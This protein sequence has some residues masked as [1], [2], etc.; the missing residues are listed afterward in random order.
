MDIT[1]MIGKTG[2]LIV[3]NP[4]QIAQALPHLRE[5]VK[6]HFTY[7]FYR[8]WVNLLAVLI[9]RLLIL[10]QHSARLYITFILRR[11]IHLPISPAAKH[12][13]NLDVRVL[14]SGIKYDVPKIKTQKP[15]DLVIFYKNHSENDV[16]NFI[17]TRIHNITKDYKI[18][19]LDLTNPEITNKDCKNDSVCKHTVLGGTFDR[20]HLAHKLLLSEAV[21]RATEKVTVGVTTE[22]MLHSKFLWELIEDMEVR[23]NNVFDF[24]KD[25]CPEL[26]YVIT[27][28]SD[29]FGP[30]IVDPTMEVII[31]SQ[32]TV[33]GGEKINE[34]R[35]TKNLTPL[36]I[37][38]VDLLDEPN[39][40]PIEESKIS[41]ST[42]RLRLLGTVLKPIIPNDNIPKKTI[43]YWTDSHKWA[44]K[45]VICGIASGKSGVAKWLEELGA[46]IIYCDLIGHNVYKPGKPCYKAIVDHFGDSVIAANGEIDRK[47][48]GGIVFSNPDQ[49]NKLNSL[50]W[51]AI[52]QEVTEIVKKSNKQVIVI[53]AAILLTA[54]WEKNCH[55]IW[56]T[57]VPREEAIK[58][59]ITRN[60]LSED[61]ANSRL[62]SQQP[63][64]YYIE[65]SNVVFCTLWDPIYTKEQV[66]KAWGLLQERLGQF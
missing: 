29:P 54:G 64:K 42:T 22:N 10:G 47:T 38:P 56:T 32:E 28:I 61:Q 3:S 15:I 21:L 30:A 49:L 14:L 16:N 66:A 35:Q 24:L 46:D 9:Q 18:L 19:H 57:L 17:Q 2:L 52:Q 55:E 39:P 6:I 60:G 45:K 4:K 20:L 1:T 58:R 33:R 36:Q 26:E 8:L 41:S 53:E 37:V 27:P 65:H 62:N 40:S 59:L 48:L 12:C 13:Y 31:V 23:V 11:N 50:V 63:N 5:R 25:I 34:I 44:L 43:Y 7:N 51:P